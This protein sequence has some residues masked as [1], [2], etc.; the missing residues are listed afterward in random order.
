MDDN[1]LS[2]NPQPQDLPQ[3]PQQPQ[4]SQQGGLDYQPM[5]PSGQNAEG[6]IRLERAPATSSPEASPASEVP[7]TPEITPVRTEQES[8]SPEV[9]K[10]AEVQH[11][12]VASQPQQPEKPSSDAAAI[13]AQATQNQKDAHVID[14]RTG[15]ELFTEVE[16]TQKLTDEADKEEQ[17]FL[18]GVLDAHKT[19][20]K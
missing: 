14:K 12:E 17:E 11:P 4:S 13:A 8:I 6:S 7:V 18:E 15:Q 9:E 2:Q 20:I 19:P 3:A 1:T 10:S 16:T 5:V